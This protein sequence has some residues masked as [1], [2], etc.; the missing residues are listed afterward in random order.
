MARNHVVWQGLDEY[1]KQL[2]NLPE[3]CTVE[4]GRL[5]E[6]TANAAYVD[7]SGAYP[8]RTGNLRRGMRLTQT[9]REGMLVK[10]VVKNVAP[11]ANIFEVGTQARH[12]KLGANR[13][14]MPPGHV[15]VPRI[16]RH[17]RA[18]TEKLKAMV[19]RHGAT[20]TGEP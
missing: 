7:I 20:V 17:R 8:S 11:H 1:R 19:A 18:L 5:I 14:S 2:A 6:G 15:F 13:G 10:A 3:D 12:T 4:S 9:R 16:V